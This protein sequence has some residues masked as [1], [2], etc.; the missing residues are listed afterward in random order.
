MVL[1]SEQL[2]DSITFYK[3]SNFKYNEELDL[4][5]MILKF[6]FNT[7]NQPEWL[8]SMKE[9]CENTLTINKAYDLLKW[10]ELN[11]HGNVPIG[12]ENI[13]IES[14]NPVEEIFY[15]EKLNICSFNITGNS[16]KEE[17]LLSFL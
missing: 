7:A 14:Y 4:C 15:E 2:E 3:I 10:L 8:F 17:E 9:Y 16:E 13:L 1:A 6:A 5:N 11:G 12:Q